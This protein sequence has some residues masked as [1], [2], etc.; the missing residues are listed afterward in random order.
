MTMFGNANPSFNVWSDDR[1]VTAK[2]VGPIAGST[3]VKVVA[4]G[5]FQEPHVSTCGDG[6]QAFGV[7]AWDVV[8]GETLTVQQL[9][10]WTVK[11]GTALVAPQQIQSDANGKAIV[12]AA[13]KRLG[14]I[15][16]DAANNADAA[17]R[18]SL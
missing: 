9:G 14:S 13:G 17:V 18:L 4:G 11:A 1:A 3:F 15:Y 12:L 10:T 6:E 5:T 2:A 8:D 7:A 16:S